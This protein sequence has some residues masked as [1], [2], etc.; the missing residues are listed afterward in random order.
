MQDLIDSYNFIRDKINYIDG[1]YQESVSLQKSINNKIESIQLE[2][3]NLIKVQKYF[4]TYIEEC[5][6][7]LFERISNLVTKGIQEIFQ[8]KSLKFQINHVI[9]R[10]RSSL[11]LKII[12]NDEEFPIIGSFGG[13]LISVIS[14]ILRCIALK[15]LQLKKFLVLDEPFAH[16]DEERVPAT[17]SFLRK[18]SEEL[19]IDI[20]LV[21]HKNG[22]S[23][24]AHQKYSLSSDKNGFLIKRKSND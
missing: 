11:D 15:N 14:I 17:A 16:L 21:T 4:S 3:N 10:D 22:F 2:I 8:D 5:S 6:D 23:E 12:K 19:N 9:K 1:R 18:L 13:G 20:L 7:K 24:Y